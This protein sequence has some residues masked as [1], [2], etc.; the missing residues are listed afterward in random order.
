MI[1]IQISGE[2]REALIFQIADLLK[3]PAE[4]LTTLLAIGDVDAAP[5]VK[6]ATAAIKNVAAAKAAAAAG[7]AAGSGN[8]A[9]LLDDDKPKA[10]AAA[11]KES[12]L[13]DDDDAAP[14]EKEISLDMLKKVLVAHISKHT[15]KVTL[16]LM[17][18]IG[19][20]DKISKLDPKHYAA[21]YQAVT[22][23]L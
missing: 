7:K 10:T 19:K 1:R 8:G 5:A 4:A 20:A 11:A 9:G 12:S 21:V 23:E 17:K 15:E 3:L 14:P 13:L 2:T 16:A 18:K 6:G 22:A